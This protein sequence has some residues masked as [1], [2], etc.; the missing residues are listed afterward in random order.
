MCVCCG[1][2]VT[3]LVAWLG[4]CAEVSSSI[5]K[6]WMAWRRAEAVRKGCSFVICTVAKLH[7][8]CDVRPCVSIAV[9]V[10]FLQTSFHVTVEFRVFENL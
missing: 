10:I 2:S 1:M 6:H 7:I 9:K 5:P 8:A 3:V 4:Q